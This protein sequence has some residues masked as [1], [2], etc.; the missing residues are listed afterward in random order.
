MRRRRRAPAYQRFYRRHRVLCN[1]VMAT[2]SIV[3]V[4]FYFANHIDKDEYQRIM[5]SLLLFG[6]QQMAD[7]KL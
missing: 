3:S 7:R 4:Q 5:F 1:V 6:L 2:V